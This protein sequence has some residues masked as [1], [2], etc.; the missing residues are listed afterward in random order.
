MECGF[1][2]AWSYC[3]IAGHD[4]TCS[5][6]GLV[7]V[8]LPDR[9]PGLL[10]AMWKGDCRDPRQRQRVEGDHCRYKVCL[11]RAR[12]AVLGVCSGSCIEVEKRFQG[13][14][15]ELGFGFA[16][17]DNRASAG[18]EGVILRGEHMDRLFSDCTRM[19]RTGQNPSLC[20]ATCK[21][22]LCNDAYI[23]AW[24]E[25]ENVLVSPRRSTTHHF[26]RARSVS[27]RDEL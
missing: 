23:E 10:L 27:S 25:E 18:R 11:A 12:V 9:G 19:D 13:T 14:K 17:Q 24:L 26:T 20:D 16:R 21:G 15:G 1:R 4:G 22:C 5:Y 2:S 3:M 8:P 6:I 7:P